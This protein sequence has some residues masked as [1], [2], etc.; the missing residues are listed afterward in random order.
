MYR[1]NENHMHISGRLKNVDFFFRKLCYYVHIS[2]FG[3]LLVFFIIT[4]HVKNK[5]SSTFLN[6]TVD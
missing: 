4:F 1:L 3:E 2:D 5:K 6:A